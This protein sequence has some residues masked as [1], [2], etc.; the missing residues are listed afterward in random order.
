[1]SCADERVLLTV[2]TFDTVFADQPVAPRTLVQNISQEQV[3]VR[4]NLEQF[5]NPVAASPNVS[6]TTYSRPRPLGPIFKGY[7][8]LLKVLGRLGRGANEALEN[9]PLRI[10]AQS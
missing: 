5:Q 2:S 9:K 6:P 3:I 4:E 10:V 8:S 1:M 7:V